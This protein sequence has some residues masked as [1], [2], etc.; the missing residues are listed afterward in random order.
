[1]AHTPEMDDLAIVGSSMV[2]QLLRQAE[3]PITLPQVL[4]RLQE[5]D[6]SAFDRYVSEKDKQAAAAKAEAQQKL[7]VPISLLPCCLVE[8][9][10]QPVR[11]LTH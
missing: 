1:M 2:E 7:L 5:Q 3:A 9:A 10:A 8:L 6:Q 11:T 4:Q